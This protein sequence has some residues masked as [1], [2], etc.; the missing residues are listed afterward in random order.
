MLHNSARPCDGILTK[1]AQVDPQEVENSIHLGETLQY[2]RQQQTT[3][4][5]TDHQLMIV[6]SVILGVIVVMLSMMVWSIVES[7]L[8]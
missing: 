6:G 3:R 8:K 5:R 7:K 2:L 4:D 1:L